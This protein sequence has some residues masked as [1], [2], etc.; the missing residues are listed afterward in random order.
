MLA[1]LKVAF[2]YIGDQL[3]H[4]IGVILGFIAFILWTEL[5]SFT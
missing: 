1:T 3:Q 2:Y 4:M 5:Y